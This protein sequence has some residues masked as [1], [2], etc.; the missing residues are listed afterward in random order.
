MEEMNEIEPD[1]KDIGGYLVTMY[2]RVAKDNSIT[3]KI[4]RVRVVMFIEE[5]VAKPFGAD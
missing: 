3:G 4:G 2:S 5:K 1:G